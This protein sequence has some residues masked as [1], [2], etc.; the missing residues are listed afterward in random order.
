VNHKVSSHNGRQILN[1]LKNYGLTLVFLT[2]C[3]KQQDK[4]LKTRKPR[5]QI[6]DAL[7]SPSML[8]D[9]LLVVPMVN[10]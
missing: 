2:Q 10:Q 4:S 6:L 1:Q 7:P 8:E 9:F 3:L 5:A